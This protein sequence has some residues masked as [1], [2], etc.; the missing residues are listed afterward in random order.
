MKWKVWWKTKVNSDDKEKQ[1]IRRLTL[2]FLIF[3]LE[4]SMNKMKIARWKWQRVLEREKEEKGMNKRKFDSN[5]LNY[6]NELFDYRHRFFIG[7]QFT[8]SVVNVQKLL[9][10]TNNHFLLILAGCI[11]VL[12]FFAM[13]HTHTEYES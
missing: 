13:S 7:R 6:Q 5:S 8:L 10:N 3:F 4:L 9:N 11:G 2:K 12:N 1:K